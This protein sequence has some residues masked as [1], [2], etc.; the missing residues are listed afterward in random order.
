MVSIRTWKGRAPGARTWREKEACCHP[1]VPA[2]V[3]LLA[4]VGPDVLLSLGSV[5]AQLSLQPHA[6][7]EVRPLVETNSEILFLKTRRI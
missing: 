1:G 5:R 3:L 2:L 6:A 7:M 4:S